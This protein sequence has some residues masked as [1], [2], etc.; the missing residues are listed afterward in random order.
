MGE[1]LF[2]GGLFTTVFL[3]ALFSKKTHHLGFFALMM[4]FFLSSD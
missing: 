2:L 1:A 3:F 4:C